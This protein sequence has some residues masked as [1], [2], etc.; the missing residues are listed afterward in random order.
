[1]TLH[2]ENE[3][4]LLGMAEDVVDLS[5][6]RKVDFSHVFPNLQHAGA[7]VEAFRGRGLAVEV[8]TFEDMEHFDITVSAMLVP[9]AAE[10]TEFEER[11]GSF[12]RNYHGRP[13]GWLLL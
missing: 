4:I 11:L 3:Q 12:A 1:M 13:D 2:D 5:K 9:N 6:M 10:I 7:L 8:T